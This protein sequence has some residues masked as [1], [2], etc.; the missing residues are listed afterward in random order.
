MK[1]INTIIG[2]VKCCFAAV[3]RSDADEYYVSYAYNNGKF[4]LGSMN[5]QL[6]YRIKSIE[7]INIIR[8]HIEE[9]YHKGNVVVLSWQRFA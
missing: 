6:A 9:T 5:I 7:D 2:K 8:T 4:G 3:M 1:V